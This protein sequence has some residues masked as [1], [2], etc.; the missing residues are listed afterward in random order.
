MA[1]VYYNRWCTIP[2]AKLLDHAQHQRRRLCMGRAYTT[3]QLLT[4]GMSRRPRRGPEHR[5]LLK[6]GFCNFENQAGIG[7]K[8]SALFIPCSSQCN[9]E[10]EKNKNEK[11]QQYQ[12]PNI[13]PCLSLQRS[14]RRA[15]RQPPPRLLHPITVS[16][17]AGP[18]ARSGKSYY[19]SR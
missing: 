6:S 18:R 8:L 2:T 10:M 5:I 9:T 19:R 14:T 13:W 15:P 17:R 16:Y 3:S 7:Q 4:R 1:M 12:T 11:A